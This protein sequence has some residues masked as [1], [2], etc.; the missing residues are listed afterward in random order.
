MTYPR[1]INVEK[2]TEKVFLKIAKMYGSINNYSNTVSPLAYILNHNGNDIKKV[3]FNIDK[4]YEDYVIPD[5][6][7]IRDMVKG[8]EYTDGLSIWSYKGLI[9]IHYIEIDE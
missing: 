6:D 2:V 5:H 8:F 1:K 7:Y 3:T 9:Y 4:L